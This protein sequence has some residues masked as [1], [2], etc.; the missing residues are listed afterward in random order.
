M[1]GGTAYASQGSDPGDLLYPVKITT[2]DARLLVAGD[3]E[4]KAELNLQ[5]AQTRLEEMD[6][7]AAGNSENISLAV[8][9]YRSNLE[10]V[11]RETEGVAD[12]AALSGLLEKVSLQLSNQLQFCE[13]KIDGGQGSKGYFNEACNIAVQ[14]QEKTLNRLTEQNMVRAAELN[15]GVMENRLQRALNMA[16]QQQYQLMQEAAVQYQQ[17][18][19]LG[20]QIL[21]RART[22]GSQTASVES[23]SVEKLQNCA[24]ILSEL[25]EQVSGEYQDTIE[26]CQELTYQ[27]QSQARYGSPDNGNLSPGPQGQGSP[28]QSPQPTSQNQGSDTSGKETPGPSGTP[29]QGSGEQSGNV[30]GTPGASASPSPSP[31]G[32]SQNGTGS[33]PGPGN[34]ENGSGTISGIEESGPQNGN[35]SAGENSPGPKGNSGS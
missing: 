32:D 33:G 26:A 23:L 21:E 24:G 4:L 2:E 22:M 34:S 18:N 13:N 12:T 20:M 11:N 1:T 35:G 28:Q 17:F 14:Q 7:L 29:Y 30:N 16:E 6:R 9:G 27:F 8:N 10:A 5:Y 25:S 15:L 3:S 31:E 19:R